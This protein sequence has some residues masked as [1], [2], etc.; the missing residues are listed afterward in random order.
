[1]KKGQV[2]LAAV[3][4]A[5][6][7]ATA[8]FAG[9]T[10]HKVSGYMDEVRSY[11]TKVDEM[12]G[13][14]SVFKTMVT[15]AMTK[16][17]DG[18]VRENTEDEDNVVICGEYVIRS[19]KSIS[20][21]YISGDRSG[22]SDQE[23]ETLDMAKAVLDE[24]IEDGMDNYEKEKAVYK[25][26]TM[27]LK[28][29]NSIL[30][31][32]PTVPDNVDNPY[33]VLKYGNAVCVGYAT[34]FRLL[35][36]M[37]GMECKVVHSA[38]LV[39]SWD[40]IK[41]DDGEWYHVDCYMDHDQGNFVNFNMTDDMAASSHTWTHSFFPAAKG[42]EYNEMMRN[43]EDIEGVEDIPA[44]YKRHFEN[45]DSA[46]CLRIGKELSHDDELRASY[47]TSRL[48][49]RLCESSSLYDVRTTWIKAEDGHYLLLVTFSFP[50][51]Y[52]GED[53]EELDIEEKD[54]I[55]KVIE[56]SFPESEFPSINYYDG[57]DD[58][59]YDADINTWG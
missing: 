18:L 17:D 34:T 9:L 7:A 15:E 59:F 35:V 29:D 20:D 6:V 37:L 26:L 32:I 58:Y 11:G 21:A 45:K 14:M 28:S 46:F 49:S 3:I 5:G 42:L 52:T 33:G 12:K 56:K 23:K 51:N 55:E 44:A 2:V 36:N 8:T 19:T 16:D 48:Y 53:D 27:E 31:V 54:R 47:I 30:T 41:M 13:E 24:I 38:D 50:E 22:L 10:L 43:R 25:Y 57:D 39:H 4:A 40:L 1:M